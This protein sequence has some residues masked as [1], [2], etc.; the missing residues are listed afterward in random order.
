MLYCE[1]EFG[2]L[3]IS[4]LKLCTSNLWSQH[5]VKETNSSW[6]QLGLSFCNSSFP[7]AGV[8]GPLSTVSLIAAP[9]HSLTV[10]K[11][12]LRADDSASS[13]CFCSAGLALGPQNLLRGSAPPHLS[14]PVLVLSGPNQLQSFKPSLS[15]MLVCVFPWPGCCSDW[16]LLWTS[17]VPDNL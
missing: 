9:G 12:G 3:F 11:L 16:Y 7:A 15:A 1:I 8:I 4:G 6:S 5:N 2:F 13:N 17:L 14:R 10:A